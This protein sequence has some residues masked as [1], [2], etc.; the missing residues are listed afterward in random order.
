MGKAYTF[1]VHFALLIPMTPVQSDCILSC[2]VSAEY[3]TYIPGPC[4]VPANRKFA[5]YSIK[6]SR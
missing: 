2:W 5:Y 6:S 4:I 3:I 1:H